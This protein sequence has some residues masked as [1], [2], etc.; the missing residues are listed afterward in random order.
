MEHI[1][2]RLLYTRKHIFKSNQKNFAE[3]LG[4]SQG[5]LSDIENGNRNLSQESLT[6]LYNRSTG[7]P[8]FSFG[9]LLLGTG[10]PF[11]T[12]VPMLP[13]DEQE[14]LDC[15]RQLDNRG[16]HIV[17]AAVYTELDRIN[18]SKNQG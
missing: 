16:Q 9:W 2:I 15:Y 11:D 4:I 8:S 5:A 13:E 18:Y 14:L 17:H 12:I 10:E 1:G 6:C 3:I 7:E